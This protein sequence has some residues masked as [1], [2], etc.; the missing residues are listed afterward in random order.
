M[1]TLKW[2]T[3][4]ETLRAIQDDIQKFVDSGALRSS[5]DLQLVKSSLKVLA[6]AIIEMSKHRI[7]T[8]SGTEVDFNGI[9]S[10]LIDMLVT[11]EKNILDVTSSSL[12][13]ESLSRIVDHSDAPALAQHSFGC[14]MNLFKMLSWLAIPVRTIV[15]VLW[16]RFLMMNGMTKLAGSKG[17]GGDGNEITMFVKIDDDRAPYPLQLL[18]TEFKCSSHSVLINH[19]SVST[20]DVAR[21][22]GLLRQKY[23]Q[24]VIGTLFKRVPVE[25][26]SKWVRFVCSATKMGELLMTLFDSGKINERP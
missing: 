25:R 17:I 23:Q 11:E 13:V 24:D 9:P 19:G 18:P 4:L 5:D 21:D 16:R 26:L 7:F 6:D 10:E 22:A 2:N 1:Q 12:S 14:N 3:H 15:Q 20:A 8:V